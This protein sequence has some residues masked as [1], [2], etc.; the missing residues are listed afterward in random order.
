MEWL[1]V[2]AKTLT[3]AEEIALDQ[4]GVDR[5]EAEFA[6]IDEPKSGLLGLGRVDARLRARVKPMQ[7]PEKQNQQRRGK[8][9]RSKS[10]SNSRSAS[11]NRTGNSRVHS[12]GYDGN[13]RNSRNGNRNRTQ[14]SSSA[15]LETK[16]NSSRSSK[17]LKPTA[18]K[19]GTAMEEPMS[20]EDQ[21]TVLVDFLDG[22]MEAFDLDAA[23]TAERVDDETVEMR[24]DNTPGVGL[25]IGPKGN[26]LRAVEDLSRMLVQR[27]SD[28]NCEGRIRVDVGGYRERRKAALE[29]FLRKDCRRGSRY[30]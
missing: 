8:N 5:S 15:K 29:E 12:R 9:N 19:E 4:L 11:N 25:L 1:E 13:N 22:L 21:S 24:V 20:L 27:K 16:I 10:R 30:R 14:R 2:T 7:P 18:L 23:V 6:V 26:T 28:G 17:S 3:Q